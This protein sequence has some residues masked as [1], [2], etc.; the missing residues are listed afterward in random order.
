[1]ENEKR[2]GVALWI[3]V[4]IL[5]VIFGGFSMNVEGL[6]AALIALVTILVTSAIVSVLVAVWTTRKDK[7]LSYTGLVFTI[8]ILGNLVRLGLDYVMGLV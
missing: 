8:I 7:I 5:Y 1:M 6:T 3:V 4:V 2:F